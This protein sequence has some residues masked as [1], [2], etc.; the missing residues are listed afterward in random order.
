METYKKP[1]VASKTGEMM[2]ISLNSSAKFTAAP[3]DDNLQKINSQ[4]LTPRKKSAE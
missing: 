4:A 1:V 2:I 3:P